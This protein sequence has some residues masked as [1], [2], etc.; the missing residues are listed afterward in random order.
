MANTYVDYTGD[1]SET[2]F[3]FSF[4]YIKTSHVV[5]E[6]NEGQGAGGLNKWVRKTL[7]TDYSVQTSPST[8]VRFVTAPA[9]NVRIRVLRDSDASTGIVDFANGSVL[10]ETELDNSYEHNRYL[11]EEAEEGITGGALVKNTDGQF[12]ADGLR[13]E[14]LADPDSDDDAVNKGYADGRFV[15]VTGDT[16]TGALSM[17]NNVI[18]NIAN[19]G[20]NQDA[21][22]KKYVDDTDAARK[23]YID[24]ATATLTNDKVSKSGDTMTGNLAMTNNKVTNLGSPTAGTDATNKTYVDAQ[25][26][27]SIS[28]GVPG[29]QIQTANI[30]ELAVETAKIADG[31]VETAKIENDAVT[32]A[33]M[34]DINSGN[35]IG[36]NIR[37]PADTGDPEEVPILDEDNMTTNS[38][39]SLATQQSI[40]AYVDNAVG[41]VGGTDLGVTHNEETVTVTSSTGDNITLNAATASDSSTST[42]GT[43]GVMTDGDKEKL[44][45]IATG[46]T[47]NAGTVTQVNTSGGLTG[48]PITDS[49]TLSI[50][51][52]GVTSDKIS[53]TDTTFNVGTTVGVGAVS[54]DDYELEVEKTNGTVGIALFTDNATNSL[55]KVENRTASQ[56]VTGTSSKIE[57]D[58]HAGSTN[59]ASVN[60][61]VF[62][63]LSAGYAFVT[64]N[65]GD[66]CSFRFDNTGN[67]SSRG[68]FLPGVD[69]AQI[70]GRP[71]FRWEDAYVVNG[72]TTGS[73]I[74]DKQDIAELD[75]AER[76]VATAAKGLIKK[77]RWIK[78][79]QA[80]GDAARIHVGIMAQ[81][82]EAAFAAEGLNAFRYGMLCKDDYEEK[83]NGVM[84]QKTRYSVRYTELLAFIISAL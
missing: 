21:A 77:F 17:G 4:P 40:K 19:P 50:A 10:T 54:N 74:N 55:V 33:K 42:A 5:V 63:S 43:A 75:E 49:G 51:V 12:D 57:L 67:A 70:L 3:N 39:T 44:D 9:N 38:D 36:R 2:D 11:A 35:V 13:L 80:K 61:G 28:T 32:F 37:T 83:V 47:A 15:N 29:G 8:F 24:N 62:D 46:A 81:E 59:H 69:A 20:S 48:G 23:T 76:R 6:V 34:Q 16:M 45:G 73:D 60:I 18:T 71:T 84:T 27:S 7:T 72:V 78:D 58:A 64:F 41:G 82:L 66:Q 14:N 1:G 79:V 25:I 26:A 56:Q 65:N 30:A 52:N 53:S 31:A 22:T 68:S